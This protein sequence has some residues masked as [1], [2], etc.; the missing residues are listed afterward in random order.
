[1]D[2]KCLAIIPARGGSKRIPKKNIKIF[3]DLPI[4]AYSINS[5]IQ[6]DLFD[7]VMVSTD[8]QEIAD[9]SLKYN[10]KI[11]FYRSSETANDFATISEV[12][13]EVLKSYLKI[14]KSFD[15]VC[16]IYATAPFV[17]ADNI[18]KSYNLLKT[19]DFNAILPVIRYSYPIQRALTLN[20]SFLKMIDEQYIN[21]RSQD[22]NPTYHDAGQFFWIRTES[23]LKG[24]KIFTDKL[25]A[26][27]VKE[28]EAQDID[29]IEDWKIAEYKYSYFRK[30]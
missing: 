20:N 22:L 23:I 26:I 1:M 6:A 19:N 11:P 17:S 3:C 7:E 9:I 27:I 16:L 24:E 25:G 15:N 28:E 12:I 10:A 29:T 18:I 4:I 30:K 2:E 14:G 5:A 8:D 21:T 13:I